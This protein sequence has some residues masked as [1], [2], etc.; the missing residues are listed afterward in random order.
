MGAQSWVSENGMRST[1][2][3][4]QYVATNVAI[5]TDLHKWI[6]VWKTHIVVFMVMFTGLKTLTEIGQKI[7]FCFLPVTP[8][9]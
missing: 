2:N 8:L 4:N 1:E 5:M 7:M 6:N 3:K 9:I